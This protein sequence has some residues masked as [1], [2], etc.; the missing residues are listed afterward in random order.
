MRLTI[1]DDLAD[2]Y[3]VLA[4]Q[5]RL[6]VEDLLLRQLARYQALSPLAPAVVL[7]ADDLAQIESLL[8]GGAI[9]S[10]KALL[11]RIQR[12]AGITFGQVRVPLSAAQ[13]EEIQ[14]RAEH[15][16]KTPKELVEE[17]V[18]Q[19]APQWFHCAR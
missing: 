18:A 4:Q 11:S 1:P 5:S 10:T 8:G 16:G 19:M 2:A 12:W 3:A 13:L 15:L 6:P 7:T 14:H 17:T 9:G